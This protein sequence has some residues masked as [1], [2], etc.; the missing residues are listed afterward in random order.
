VGIDG[1]ALTTIG[2]G[3]VF[4]WSGVK[5]W[6]VL[7]TLG[8]LV[9]GRTPSG[10]NALPLTN[11]T[12]TSG[13]AIP[14]TVGPGSASNQSLATL[15]L[16]YVGHAYSYGGRPGADGTGAW[17]CSSFVNYLVGVK[18][19]WAIP[20]YGPGKY[21]GK[22]HGPTTIQW[23]SWDAGM[24]RITRQEVGAGDIIV[25]F[26]HMG[27]ALSNNTMVSALNARVGTAT[28]AIEGYGNGPVL[29]YGRIKF[30]VGAERI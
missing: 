26:G 5:G 30:N 2:V 3:I 24:R 19:G 16:S 25:W 7:N 21:D 4:A 10:T 6:N 27:V 18:L 22:S 23:G 9:A 14:Q 20:G 29:M 13:R 17:D 1:K 12:S 15:A 8:D 28:S 11:D